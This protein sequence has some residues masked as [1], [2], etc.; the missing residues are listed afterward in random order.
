MDALGSGVDG[1]CRRTGRHVAIPGSW[2]E[3]PVRSSLGRGKL[4]TIQR[5]CGH[6]SHRNRPLKYTYNGKEGTFGGSD[7][8]LGVVDEKRGFFILLVRVMSVT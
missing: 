4:H 1:T 8:V 6:T 7:R 2:R 3:G 5:N